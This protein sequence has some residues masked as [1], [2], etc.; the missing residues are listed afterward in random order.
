MYIWYI[1]AIPPPPPLFLS[2]YSLAVNEETLQCGYVKRG[3]KLPLSESEWSFGE[4]II[5]YYFQTPR[6]NCSFQPSNDSSHTN[7]CSELGFEIKTNFSFSKEPLNATQKCGIVRMSRHSIKYYRGDVEKDCD[8]HYA[9]KVEF[10]E[11]TEKTY[12]CTIEPRRN[13]LMIDT[14][15][16]LCSQGMLPRLQAKDGSYLTDVYTIDGWS[17]LTNETR[18]HCNLIDQDNFEIIRSTRENV[19]NTSL[20]TCQGWI[21]RTKEDIESCCQQMGVEYIGDIS[22]TFSKNKTIS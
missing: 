20:G 19:R 18:N 13:T 22:T 5:K 2:D 11:E 21:M 9:C 4:S 15:N 1:T 10:C 12:Y 8:E 16:N 7:C 6:G 14:E 17:R 3:H